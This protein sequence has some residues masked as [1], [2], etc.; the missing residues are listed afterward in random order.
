MRQEAGNLSSG[1]VSPSFDLGQLHTHTH[2]EEGSRADLVLGGGSAGNQSTPQPVVPGSAAPSLRALSP[3]RHPPYGTGAVLAACSGVSPQLPGHSD[4]ERTQHVPGWH[5]TAMET[6]GRSQ[7]L[8]LCQ[9]YG[10]G[11]T[12]GS[13]LAAQ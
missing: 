12:R 8:T 1:A 9:G 3:T 7:G 6:K 13:H 11:G 4:S 2:T 5:D 10:T